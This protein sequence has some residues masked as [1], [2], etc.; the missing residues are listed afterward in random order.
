MLSGLYTSNIIVI[1]LDLGNVVKSE[2]KILSE[3]ESY[4][5]SNVLT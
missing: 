5:W 2:K 1:L 4:S 3:S